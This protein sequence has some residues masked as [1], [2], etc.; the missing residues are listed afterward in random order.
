MGWA[1]KTLSAALE[2]LG[3]AG[4]RR[5]DEDT[6]E[7]FETEEEFSEDDEPE[8]DIVVDYRSK[9]LRLALV[10]R[11]N[12]GK[13]SLFN[14]LLGEERSLTGPEAGLTRD[15]IAAPWKDGRARSPAARHRGP[16]QE[17][18]GR[19][20]NAGG[21][22]GRLDA[23]RHPLCRLRDRDDRCHRALRKTGSDHRRPDRARG[24]RH[25]LRRQQMGSGGEQERAPISELREKLDRLLPQV[26]GAPLVA[27][28]AR[29]G[30]GLDR[31]PKPP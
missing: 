12:V 19:G 5:E 29:T 24:P 16:A 8:E 15:A 18:A 23:G 30:E 20:R 25:R 9:P 11:P 13:S 10:G 22:V 6:E 14:R 27:I 4:D 1:W 26:A 7:P 31:L 28:S 17:S 2:P 3:A 21:N